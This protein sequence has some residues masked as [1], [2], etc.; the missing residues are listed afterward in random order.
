MSITI[1]AY[2]IPIILTLFLMCGT[3]LQTKDEFDPALVVICGLVGALVI[4][5]VWT[6]F[7]AIMYFCKEGGA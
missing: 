3:W 2:W 1:S 7:F 6:I 5:S 4:S